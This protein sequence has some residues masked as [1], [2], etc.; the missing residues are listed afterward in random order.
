MDISFLVEKERK[1]INQLSTQVFYGK[2]GYV[3][4]FII[5]G[6]YTA[7]HFHL[8]L[9]NEVADLAFEKILFS[10]TIYWSQSEGFKYKYYSDPSLIISCNQNVL[11]SIGSLKGGSSIQIG[12]SF[13]TIKFLV[14]VS[15]ADLDSS[16][17]THKSFLETCINLGIKVSNIKFFRSL[18]LEGANLTKGRFYNIIFEE[19][20]LDYV[21][22]E[23]AMFDNVK[24]CRVTLKNTIFDGCYTSY[25]KAKIVSGESLLFREIDTFVDSTFNKSVLYVKFENSN[26][27]NIDFSDVKFVASSFQDCKLEDVNFTKARFIPYEVRN[28]RGQGK[29][30]V[31]TELVAVCSIGSQ[32]NTLQKGTIRN[33]KFISLVSKYLDFSNSFII[34][35]DFENARL[36]KAKFYSC[37]L[38]E[39]N[40]AGKSLESS[41]LAGTDLSNSKLLSCNF[42][43]AN[44]N[45]VRMMGTVV[46]KSKFIGTI[47]SDSDLTSSSFTQADLTG[48]DFRR[49]NLTQL[50]L[51][52][53]TLNSAKFYQTQRGGLDLKIEESPITNEKKSKFEMA[54]K[55]NCIVKCVDWSPKGDGEIQIDEESFLSIVAGE[56]PPIAIL[57]KSEASQIYFSTYNQASAQSIS[58]SA[59]DTL[60]DSSLNAGNDIIDS[61]IETGSISDNSDSDIEDLSNDEDANSENVEGVER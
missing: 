15:K 20:C 19:T 38:F 54:R 35:S 25:S 61:D 6:S 5:S 59:G 10:M 11:N 28:E 44:M 21:S 51:D 1:N 33:C 41:Y 12:K 60:N 24:F 50:I 9:A 13:V 43:Q 23:G 16:Y 4:S 37:N 31:G 55:S 34:E 47:F 3:C 18:G 14:E 48:I 42:S 58:K 52:K 29:A 7:P 30:K 56:K 17:L 39:T 57:S 22:F 2:D 36:E 40:F 26:L 46:E 32:D 49:S 53:C 27:T 8:L 45:R